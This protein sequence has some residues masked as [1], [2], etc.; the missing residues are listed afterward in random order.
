ML[1][2]REKEGEW[3][4]VKKKEEEEEEEGRRRRREGWRKMVPCPKEE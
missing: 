1:E 4:K 2:T 3:E